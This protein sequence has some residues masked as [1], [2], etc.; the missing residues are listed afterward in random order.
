MEAV[1]LLLLLIGI[2]IFLICALVKGAKTVSN[3]NNSERLII[4]KHEV[5]LPIPAKSLCKITF[6]DC[7]ITITSGNH[8]FNLSHDK[9][10]DI[11]STTDKEIQEHYVSSV[12]GAVGGAILFGP[13]GAIVGGRSKKKKS[14]KLINYFT[15]SYKDEDELKYI[16]FEYTPS[17]NSISVIKEFNKTKGSEVVNL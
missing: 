13:L 10:T 8:K 14:S 15:I 2:A 3:P 16:S 7:D 12:G 9:I 1:I 17:F 5:G 6:K 4:C 11:S